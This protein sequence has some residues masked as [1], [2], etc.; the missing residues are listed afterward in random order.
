MDYVDLFLL[1]VEVKRFRLGWDY[2]IRKFRR[3]P[4]IFSVDA[5]YSYLLSAHYADGRQTH[6][7]GCNPEETEVERSLRREKWKGACQSQ[8]PNAGG[9]VFG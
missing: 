6:Q 7:M 9:R 2:R 8:V 1:E 5:N 4:Q 3:R